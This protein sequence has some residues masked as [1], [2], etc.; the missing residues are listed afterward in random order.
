MIFASDQRSAVYRR[1]LLR[2]RVAE[3]RRVMRNYEAWILLM[4]AVVGCAVDLMTLCLRAII[5]VAHQL[6]FGLPQGR[7]LSAQHVLNPGRG[8][9]VPTLG[10][11]ALGFWVLTSNRIRASE[12]VD[13]VEANAL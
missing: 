1:R 11:L 9:L 13:P 6:S 3:L 10:G 12:I 8:F 5:L 2:R 4:S 7:Y